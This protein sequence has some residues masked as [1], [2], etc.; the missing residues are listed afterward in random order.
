MDSLRLYYLQEMGI[1]PWQLRPQGSPATRLQTPTSSTEAM[2]CLAGNVA[3]CT[4]C[5]LHQS[6]TQTVFARGNPHARLMIIGEAPGFFEDQQGLPFV[7]KAGGLLNR[8]LKSIQLTS[9]E[10][11][12]TNVLKC[13]PPENRDPTSDEVQACSEHLAQQIL[14]VA[15]SV[16]LAVGRFAGQFLLRKSLP[17]NTMRGKI[18]EYQGIPVLITYHPAYLLRNPADKRKAY[19]DLLQVKS[20][21]HAEA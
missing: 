16:I 2:Q 1:M 8:M 19:I 7:G 15:P 17:L 5:P 6:R 12:I 14:W 21:L 13:R 10:V 9:E 3:S 11:Y 20:K 18:H 4:R